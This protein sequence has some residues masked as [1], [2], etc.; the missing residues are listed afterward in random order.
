MTD[1]RTMTFDAQ[2]TET[3]QRLGFDVAA[4]RQSAHVAGAVEIT[5]TRAADTRADEFQ[6]AITLPSGHTVRALKR[7]TRSRSTLAS[8][9]FGF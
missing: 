6:V 3:L 2:A 5:V 7:S 8:A 9:G 1:A 4:D